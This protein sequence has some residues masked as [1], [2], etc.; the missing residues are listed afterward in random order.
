MEV[1]DLIRVISP[2]VLGI[3]AWYVWSI[4]QSFVSQE[5]FK[6]YKE[7]QSAKIHE[8]ENRFNKKY[9][10][11]SARINKQN[12]DIVEIK[13]DIKHIA[14]AMIEIKKYLFEIKKNKNN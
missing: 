11:L 3:I 9:D 13:T 7:S 10:E 5:K 6:N 1:S 4:K 14:E 2:V 8:L 12:N